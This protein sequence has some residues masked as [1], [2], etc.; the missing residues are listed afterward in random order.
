MVLHHTG[1]GK[2][3]LVI[4]IKV[5]SLVGSVF[6]TSMNKKS[7]LFFNQFASQITNSSEKKIVDHFCVN[8]LCKF[9]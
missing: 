1:E 9:S 5:A 2:L 6:G 3:T 7:Q 8:D 4:P